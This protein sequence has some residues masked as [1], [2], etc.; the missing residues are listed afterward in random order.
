MLDGLHLGDGGHGALEVLQADAALQPQLH[1]QKDG[2]AEAK[3]LDANVVIEY[4][5]VKEALQSPGSF[6]LWS[7]HPYYNEM[8]DTWS[9]GPVVN[10]RDAD[11]LERANWQALQ[12]HLAEDPTLE[13]DWYI[14]RCSH[15]AV[16]WCDHL[17]FRVL[18]EE[19]EEQTSRRERIHALIGRMDERAYDLARKQEPYRHKIFHWRQEHPEAASW[20]AI[21]IEQR[22]LSYRELMEY[23]ALHREND[24]NCERVRRWHQAL[25]DLTVQRIS[26]IGRVLYDWFRNLEDYPVADDLLFSEMEH[27]ERWELAEQEI[28]ALLADDAPEVPESIANELEELRETV[29]E[30]KA[31]EQPQADGDDAS[32]VDLPDVFET[33]YR[34][35]LISRAVNAARANRRQDY[36]TDEFAGLRTPAESPGS[37]RGSFK[38]EKPCLTETPSSFP[39]FFCPCLP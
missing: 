12:N 9:L 18:D 36:G 26:R 11:V 6:A 20:D 5:W 34:P 29:D 16:G 19:T 27:D 23:Y 37:G 4:S 31:A 2:D 30:L 25:E 39:C 15:W 8:F 33:Q 14:T 17:S 28:P 10:T 32:E 3:R 24:D 21:S 35:D 13:D 1:A 22:A 38:S 7:D